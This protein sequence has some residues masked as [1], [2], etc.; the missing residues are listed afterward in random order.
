[1]IYCGF[2]SWNSIRGAMAL[3]PNPSLACMVT[4]AEASVNVYGYLLPS[5]FTSK[6]PICLH[7]MYTSMM[8]SAV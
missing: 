6:L 3:L 1:M 4:L 7:K 8:N 5:V 2:Q